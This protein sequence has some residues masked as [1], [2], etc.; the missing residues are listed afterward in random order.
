MKYVQTYWLFLLMTVYFVSCAQSK[1]I[2]V[3]TYAFISVNRPGIIATNE[4]GK[5]LNTGTDTTLLV[6]VETKGNI[7]PEWK[8]AWKNGK[9]YMLNYS[10]VEQKEIKAGQ[11]KITG[12]EIRISAEENNKLWLLQLVPSNAKLPTPEKLNNNELM[13]Q[14]VYKKTIIN[15]KIAEAFQL[16]TAPSQ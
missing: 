9:T 3:K 13:I 11:N 16:F 8:Y 6:Y 14:A 4:E 2:V 15:K 10:Q 7:S 12:E 1:N 5:P